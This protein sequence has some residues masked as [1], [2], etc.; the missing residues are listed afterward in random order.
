MLAPRLITL[1]GNASAAGDLVVIQSQADIPFSI[2]RVY[3]IHDMPESAVRGGHAHKR[4]HELVVAAAGAMTITLEAQDGTRHRF[5]LD[6]PT[7]GL[8][9]PPL[10]WRMIS[11]YRLHSL[12]LVLA[13]E[14]YEADE[15]LRD[16][17]L[18]RRFQP[19]CDA[20]PVS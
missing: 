9:V 4:C 19:S 3:F 7:V 5:R 10:Y 17:E 13:S 8:Y 20:D 6:E 1:Q 11:D 15:Y 12:C 16:H 14:D 2:R 18:F